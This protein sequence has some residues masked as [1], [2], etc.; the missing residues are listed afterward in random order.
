MRVPTGGEAGWMQQWASPRDWPSS[1]DW[2]WKKSWMSRAPAFRQAAHCPDPGHTVGRVLSGAS[3]VWWD[4]QT[5]VRQLLVWRKIFTLSLVLAHGFWNSGPRYQH[6]DS[7]TRQMFPFSVA[8][9]QII[10]TWQTRHT[11]HP[12][13]STG[14]EV[15]HCV[16]G[17]SAQG[18]ES[19]K[20]R[21]P[22]DLLHK[23]M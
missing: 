21:C 16:G 20:S 18:H 4:T 10:L 3:P 14:Q 12:E 5:S 15:S 8:G 1:A 17:F 6:I 22:R 9:Y 23:L 13:F 19:L 7:R 2:L 11:D